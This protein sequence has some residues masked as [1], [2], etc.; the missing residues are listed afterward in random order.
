MEKLLETNWNRLL[1]Q[2]KPTGYFIISANRKE[3]APEENKKKTLELKKELE[4][5][6]FKPITVHG[7]WIEDEGLDT[8]RE[9]AE[10]S[11]FVPLF[12][13]NKAFSASQFDATSTHIFYKW[14]FDLGKKYKQESILYCPPNGKPR[15]VQTTEK[16][17]GDGPV[18]P[19][20]HFD[21]FN[22]TIHNQ[23]NAPY[24]TDLVNPKYQG[25]YNH[26]T[27]K[28]MKSP[29]RITFESLENSFKR[30]MKLTEDKSQHQNILETPYILNSESKEE[31]W[32]YDNMLRSMKENYDAWVDMEDYFDLEEIGNLEEW[33]LKHYDRKGLASSLEFHKSILDDY[34]K[35]RIA[36]NNT[37]EHY[38]RTPIKY[39]KA[40]NSNTVEIIPDLS[41]GW[42]ESDDKEEA[43]ETWAD[44]IFYELDWVGCVDC[45]HSEW[46][47][48]KLC[49]YFDNDVFKTGY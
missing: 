43:K 40:Y 14:I 17:Y 21:R 12:F 9:V 46:D 30:V 41:E 15:Y 20:T 31:A 23:K 8:E 4:D 49:I 25:G 24:Y 22:K 16:N 26:E 36:Y 5:K 32:D 10:T 37:A 45:S 13:G 2:F 29:K 3:N 6:G 44:N 33:W 27:G 38:N 47:D 18:K 34:Q 19:G 42:L 39:I 1:R 35:M 11:F 48:N 28:F 7:G